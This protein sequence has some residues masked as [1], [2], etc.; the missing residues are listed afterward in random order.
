M[1]PMKTLL[2]A[3]TLLCMSILLCTGVLAIETEDARF[4]DKTW[5][6]AVIFL[7]YFAQ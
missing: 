6:R 2:T 3:L 7:L 5:V 1:K 4:Q